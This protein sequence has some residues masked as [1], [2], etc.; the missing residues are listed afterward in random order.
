MQ[1]EAVAPRVP[2]PFEDR[3]V[4]GM[5]LCSVRDGIEP[6]RRIDLLLDLR[7]GLGAHIEGRG[8]EIGDHV[9]SQVV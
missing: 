5:N 4:Q 8:D 1:V 9:P 3:A 2:P 7:T 6:L